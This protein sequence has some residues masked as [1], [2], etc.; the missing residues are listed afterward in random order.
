MD[1]CIVAD[2]LPR[3][4]WIENT[5]TSPSAKK[6]GSP[7]NPTLS[8]E[9]FNFYKSYIH[10]IV[11]STSP[12]VICF[13]GQ[14]SWI[15]G[16]SSSFSFL[17]IISSNSIGVGTFD[18]EAGDVVNQSKYKNI[19]TFRKKLGQEDYVLK[20]LGQNYSKALQQLFAL[21]NKSIKFKVNSLQ[22]CLHSHNL[23]FTYIRTTCTEY[24]FFI[25]LLR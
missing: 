1:Q 10:S 13:C 15:V 3:H 20:M 12:D 22:P 4:F 8:K 5:S 11:E 7:E 18:I 14:Y 9:Q 21:N 6:G 19:E 2:A 23:L 25:I 16:L 24:T 17:I